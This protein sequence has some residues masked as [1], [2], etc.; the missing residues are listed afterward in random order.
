MHE[1]ESGVQVSA[2][3]VMDRIRTGWLMQVR[4]VEGRG[5]FSCNILLPSVICSTVVCCLFYSKELV[6]LWIAVFQPVLSMAGF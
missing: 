5:S 3:R 6:L 2:E 4:D 1:C